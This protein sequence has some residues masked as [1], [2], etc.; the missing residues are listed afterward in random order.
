MAKASHSAPAPSTPSWKCQVVTIDW[1]IKRYRGRC[2]YCHIPV[3]RIRNS[4]EQATR[5]HLWP[6][7]RNGFDEAENIRLACQRCN[8][9]KGQM[10]PD[11]FVPSRKHP[12]EP[13]PDPG[14][15]PGPQNTEF[16]PQDI[17]KL[18]DQVEWDADDQPPFRAPSM[19]VA[20]LIGTKRGRIRIEGYAG[21]KK[22]IGR[23]TCG[24]YVRRKTQHW[25]KGLRSGAGDQGCQRCT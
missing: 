14:Y 4:P 6:P 19:V 23:C 20:A 1:L 10:A 5:D 12:S 13:G 16:F 17:V 8:R 9:E 11:E 22:L 24:R 21:D 15:D 2:V 3:N 18:G 25:R 7:S